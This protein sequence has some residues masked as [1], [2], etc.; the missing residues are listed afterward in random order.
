[1]SILKEFQEF[2]YKGNV[3]DLAVGVIMGAAFGPIVKTL[4]DNVVMPPIGL[5][6]GGVDFS[7]Y[8]FILKA[9]NEAA[10]QPEVAISYGLFINAIINFLITA[11][12]VFLLVKAMNEAK[13]RMVKEDAAAAAPTAPPASEVY[14][15]EIRDALVKR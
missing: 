15:K 5:A 7:G 12:A 13:R 10:K 2:A 4:V 8:K 9:A 3:V 1:M 11:A 6:L 14:H